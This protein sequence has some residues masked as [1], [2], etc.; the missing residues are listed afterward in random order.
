[1]AVKKHYIITFIVVTISILLFFIAH[2]SSIKI[3]SND[4]IFNEFILKK[5][6]SKE[7]LVLSNEDQI[8]YNLYLI[9]KKINTE[10]HISPLF[11]KNIPNNLS[12]LSNIDHKRYVFINLLL[13]LIFQV[14]QEVLEQRNEVLAIVSKLLQTQLNE[15]DL[16]KIKK[17]AD[18][19]NIPVDNDN[20]WDYSLALEELLIRTDIIPIS[21]ILAMAIKESGWGSSRF[22]IQSNA[23]FGQWIFNDSLGNIPLNRLSGKK[24]SI[25]TFKS[26]SDS[27][28]SYYKNLNTHTAYSDFRKQRVALR[29]NI[30]DISQE[31][32]FILDAYIQNVIKF[33]E[34]EGNIENNKINLIPLALHLH[35]Y[36][37]Q[38]EN[39]TQ[40]LINIIRSNNLTMYDEIKG[41]TNNINPT[42]LKIQ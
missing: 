39:Y 30:Q 14:H 18:L 4:Y 25:K 28:R 26:L 41:Y 21:L 36:S 27:I 7:C 10:N 12:S 2:K 35:L 8:P 29:S 17:L 23:I 38:G 16:S 31:G 11:F 34:D 19:Y 24:H 37:E 3:F 1:M 5:G 20:F 13:P 40:D 9:F 32:E 6:Y 33:K 15:E 22:I 42:C